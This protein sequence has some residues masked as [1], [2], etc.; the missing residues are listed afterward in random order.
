MDYRPRFA[1]AKSNM[2][3]GVE[4]HVCNPSYSRGGDRRI[5]SLRPAETKA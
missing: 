5:M 3:L 2:G 1:M 4:A